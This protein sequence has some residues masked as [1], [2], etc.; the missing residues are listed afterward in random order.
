[1]NSLMP[2]VCSPVV[3]LEHKG[4]EGMQQ[5]LVPRAHEEFD[6]GNYR[7]A[8]ELYKKVAEKIGEKYFHANL[9]LCKKRM[10]GKSMRFISI[11]DEISSASWKNEFDL[12]PLTRSSYQVEIESSLSHALFLESCWK[13]NQ[14]AWE[15]AFTS[16]G[17]KHAN[18]GALCE[19]IDSAKARGLPVLFWN[20]EDPMHYDRF[21]P[22]ASRCDVIFT[23]DSNK[24]SSYIRDVPGARV[25]SLPFAANPQLCNPFQRFDGELGTICFAGSYYSVG[26]EDRKIQMDNLLP[27][28]I[29]FNGAIYDRMSKLENDRYA[30][31][32]QYK[33]F[34]REA[35]PF[36]EIV[37]VYKR[38]KIFLNVNTITDSPTMMSRRVYE[39]L[40]CGTPVISTPSRSVEEQFPGIVQ[41]AKDASEA[42][43][44]AEHLLND[45]WGWLRLSHRGYRE[46]MQK[47]TYARRAHQI[48]RALG[49]ASEH[50]EPSVSIIM[51]SNRPHFIDR[52]VTNIC[53]QTHSRIE[54][55]LV[56]QDYSKAQ[57]SELKRKLRERKSNI[58]TIKIIRD[59]GD[60]PLG[61]RLNMAATA[62]TGEYVAK[63][64]DDDFY[65]ENYLS[66]MLIPFQFGDWAL[67][68][69]REVFVYLE[70]K[71]ETLIRLKGER[72]KLTQFV[73]GPT[74]VLKRHIFAMTGFS[75]LNRGEDSGLLESLRNLGFS[76][77]AADPF[78]F[79]QFR[80]KDSTNHTWQVDDEFFV[81]KGYVV[82]TGMQESVVRL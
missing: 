6:R 21:M 47:H 72:H 76:I 73:A 52:I 2:Q 10:E 82:G 33:P 65:F 1:M 49:D 16:P 11:L 35:V 78:N 18:A 41:V 56:I 53:R 7:T 77:Y 54:L 57:E 37:D 23:T 15:Y 22:I 48:R 12:F 29:E 51:A 80:S 50:V 43:E 55:V 67:V 36:T 58:G 64:D 38:Y 34:I 44:L 39:L 71:D 30:Y 17:L 14:G 42:N 3:R 63:M 69:K 60:T 20:K 5:S 66:D 24:V 61:A 45:E 9:E 62:S 81:S 79:L 26:H 75:P 25:E 8:Y 4:G 27:T 74:F 40:G 68:G 19:A 32:P 31:P 46:V 59:D 13:G 70:G 28:I